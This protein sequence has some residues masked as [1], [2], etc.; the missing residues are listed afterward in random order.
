MSREALDAHKARSRVKPPAPPPLRE[1]VL[2]RN[3][4]S[5]ME[6]ARVLALEDMQRLRNYPPIRSVGDGRLRA[7]SDPASTAQRPKGM[8]RR[9]LRYSSSSQ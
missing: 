3:T 2:R 7:R 6:V 1:K 5:V 8:P 4:A 9:R